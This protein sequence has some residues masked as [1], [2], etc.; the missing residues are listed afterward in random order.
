MAS[1]FEL[2]LENHLGVEGHLIKISKLLQWSGFSKILKDVHSDFGPEGYDPIQMFKCL[3]LQSWHSLS[4]PGLEQSLRVRLDFLQFTG[5]CVG[6]KLPDETTFCRFRNKLISQN[7]LEKLFKEVNTQ[8]ENHG[9]KVKNANVAIVDATIISSNGRPR[10]VID[11]TDAGDYKVEYSAD[12]DAKWLKK[13][14]NFYFGYRGYARSDAEGFI[15]KTHVQPANLSE[16]K[17]LDE[18]TNDLPIGTRV[19][20]DKGFFSAANK[21]M[22]KSKKLKNGLMYKAFRNKPLT[23]RMTQFNK[24]VSKT[25]WRIEQCFGNIKRRFAYQ[26]A[27]YFTTEKVDAQFK[28]KAMCHNLLKAVNKIEFA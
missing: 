7:K 20:A 19:Q 23:G 18:M 24:L 25:R 1:F 5:F 26:K 14:K 9:L 11:A 3:L 10:K 2:D 8:L 28:M 6:D 15:D 21:A 16:S 17:E 13:G 22:L 12:P 27:S 4:D